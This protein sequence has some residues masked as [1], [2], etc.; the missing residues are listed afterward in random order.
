MNVKSHDW[1]K[2]VGY[3]R[4][5]LA[6]EFTDTYKLID[7]HMMYQV[8]TV[9]HDSQAITLQILHDGAYIKQTFWAGNFRKVTCEDILTEPEQPTGEGAEIEAAELAM[10]ERERERIAEMR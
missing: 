3:P 9:D 10:L 7:P 8:V 5:S 6:D 2:R 1:V 4:A